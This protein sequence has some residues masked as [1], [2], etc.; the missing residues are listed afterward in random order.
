MGT[1]VEPNQNKTKQKNKK[2]KKTLGHLLIPG[3][4]QCYNYDLSKVFFDA[5]PTGFYQWET[6][7]LYDNP[8]DRPGWGNRS[9]KEWENWNKVS[10]LYKALWVASI[11]ALSTFLEI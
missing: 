2:K 3:V 9:T 4:Q 8:Q 6:W 1:D 7:F 5:F 10:M 11:Q